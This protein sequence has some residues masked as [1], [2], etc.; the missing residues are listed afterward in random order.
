MPCPNTNREGPRPQPDARLKRCTPNQ[1]HEKTRHTKRRDTRKDTPKDQTHQ[2][3]PSPSGNSPL[4][5]SSAPGGLLPA[6][7]LAL[8]PQ[9]AFL[10][11]A[12]R[13]LSRA[14]LKRPFSC[15]P[16]AAFLL[17]ASSGFCFP[18]SSGLWRFD[19]RR[20]IQ[21]LFEIGKDIITMLDPHR[22]PN[23][24]GCHPGC[25]LFLG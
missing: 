13:G 9:A 12:S 8:R 6:R 17:T 11:P 22:Q 10:V 25:G 5:L 15:P 16:Q 4:C 23:I 20:L 14:R 2:K 21:R 7:F 18:A 3:G 19:F 24:A 1:S